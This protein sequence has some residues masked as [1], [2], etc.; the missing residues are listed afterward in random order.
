V[1]KLPSGLSLEN[2][3]FPDR[4]YLNIPQPPDPGLQLT[5]TAELIQPP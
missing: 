5:G 2:P 3:D 4:I 1:I